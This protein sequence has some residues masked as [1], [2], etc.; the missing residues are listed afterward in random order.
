MRTLMVLALAVLTVMAVAQDEAKETKRY[1]VAVDTQDLVEGV[2]GLADLLEKKLSGPAK[3]YYEV[4]VAKN[5]LYGWVGTGIGL[6]LMAL[7]IYFSLGAIRPTERGDGNEP[8]VW[9]CTF[10]AILCIL[11]AVILL[12]ISV[13]LLIAPEYQAMQQF[14]NTAS[15]FMP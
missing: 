2:E 6:L 13:Q 5:K 4:L 7:G 10:A 15:Q 1:E 8:K 12:A 3:D 14:I 11:V 9:A